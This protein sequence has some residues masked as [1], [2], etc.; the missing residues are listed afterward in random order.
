MASEVSLRSEVSALREEPSPISA[1][2]FLLICTL[3]AAPMA[4]GAVEPW[5]W[6]GLGALLILVLLLWALGTAR[7]ATFRIAWSPLYLPGILFILLGVIQLTFRLTEA[8]SST[9]EALLKLTID[10]VLFFLVTQLVV[11]GP[12][13]ALRQS[14][15]VVWAFAFLLGLYSILQFFSSD[16]KIYWTVPSPNVAV[17]PY[18]NRNH[19]AGLMEMLIPVAC[20]YLLSIRESHA[21]RTLLGLALLIPVTSV[22]ISGSRGGFIALFAEG[23][24]LGALL[25]RYLPRQSRRSLLAIAGLTVAAL[26][27]LS[28]WLITEEISQRVFEVAHLQQF[29][30]PDL[31]SRMT[32]SANALHILEDH[33]VVGTGLGSFEE[34]FPAYQSFP[35]DLRWDHAHNDYVEALAETGLAG[36]AIMLAGLVL[37]FRL[38]FRDLRW[39]LRHRSGRIQLGAAL[40]CCGLLVHSLVDFNLHLPANAAWFTVCL[41]LSTADLQA[42]R[43]AEAAPTGL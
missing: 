10:F 1:G 9:E 39:R 29:G 43:S 41:A 26:A 18:V 19:Y 8:R 32:V 6:G 42:Y 17:G 4:F 25:W 38:A 37:F 31:A 30:E 40:G 16:G 33:P 5:A 23:I 22:L 20:G 14:G 34:V 28:S 27:A 2:R 11:S 36:G 24:F 3:L 35:S 15:L 21:L 7:Q 13:T 12:Q